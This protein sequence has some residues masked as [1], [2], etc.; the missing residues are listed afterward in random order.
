M[1]SPTWLF[2]GRHSFV[3]LTSGVWQV[4]ETLHELSS[5]G[6]AQPP[7]AFD[8]LTLIGSFTCEPFVH[9]GIVMSEPSD[10]FVKSSDT[11]VP[12]ATPGWVF[13]ASTVVPFCANS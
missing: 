13:V 8:A 6:A 7:T 5:G 2:F 12:G 9:D 3:M 4:I 1:T 10:F 11:V